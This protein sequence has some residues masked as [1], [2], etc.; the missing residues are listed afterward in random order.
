MV[1]QPFTVEA[2]AQEI[3]Q[4]T[5][6]LPFGA[7]PKCCRTEGCDQ[8]TSEGTAQAWQSGFLQALAKEEVPP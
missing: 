4:P 1:K 2:K 8:R 7:G 6:S 5:Q 3:R